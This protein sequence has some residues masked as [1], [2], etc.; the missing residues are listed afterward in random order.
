[1]PFGGVVTKFNDRQQQIEENICKTARSNARFIKPLRDISEREDDGSEDAVVIQKP[2]SGKFDVYYTTP[3]RSHDAWHMGGIPTRQSVLAQYLR[4]VLTKCT[5]NV[6]GLYRVCWDDMNFD[7]G[8]ENYLVF[9]KFKDQH[10]ALLPD[11]YQML[12]YQHAGLTREEHQICLGIGE[13]ITPFAKKKPMTVFAGS[14]PLHLM[15]RKM[16]SICTDSPPR[17]IPSE[18]TVV[19]L[20]S[21]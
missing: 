3:P 9:S 5:T 17:S 21:A 1:M 18:S 4:R 12:D 7:A 6:S 15:I 14:R 13:G 16:N 11:V 20:A 10:V 2:A 8:A 19:Q